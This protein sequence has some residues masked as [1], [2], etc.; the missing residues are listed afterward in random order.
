[1]SARVQSSFSSFDGVKVENMETA[2]TE[3]SEMSEFQVDTL[4]GRP[5][6]SSVTSSHNNCDSCS[7]E[8]GKTGVV[9]ESEPAF[10]GL[11]VEKMEAVVA[12]EFEMSEFQVD[13]LDG[14]PTVSPVA[15]S[16]SN[17]DS[18]TNED[19]KTGVVEDPEPVPIYAA[20]LLDPSLLEQVSYAAIQWQ[21]NLTY[22]CSGLRSRTPGG[23]AARF[24]LGAPPQTPRWGSAPN[25]AG[26]TAPSPPR[27][28]GFVWSGAPMGVL[29]AEPPASHLRRSR[30]RSEAEPP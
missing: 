20:S 23:C 13:P 6:V 17:W 10:D 8:D 7:N 2:T 29:G 26:G 18:C 19:G 21:M 25:P 15:S 9:E 30:R 1:M 28:R 4:D 24:K 14:R 11:K 12:D 3:E 5:A 16:H 27:Q 22:D